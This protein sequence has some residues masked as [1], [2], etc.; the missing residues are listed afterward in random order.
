MNFGEVFFFHKKEVFILY[1]GAC[2]MD[3]WTKQSGLHFQSRTECISVASH[4]HIEVMIAHCPR[5]V[6]FTFPLGAMERSVIFHY[7]TV[8]L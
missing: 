7:L 6:V 5:F 3:H 8:H 4:P 2:C 1:F